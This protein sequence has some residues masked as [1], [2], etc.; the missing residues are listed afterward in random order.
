VVD[1]VWSPD[2]NTIAFAANWDGNFDIYIMDVHHFIIKQLTH[3]DGDSGYRFP[4]WSPDGHHLTFLVY[5][6]LDVG[7]EIHIM[8]AD[9]SGQRL[10]LDSAVKAETACFLTTRPTSLLADP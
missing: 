8:N 9:G 6:G 10:L 7:G 5:G 4:S 3:L 2:G 1:G